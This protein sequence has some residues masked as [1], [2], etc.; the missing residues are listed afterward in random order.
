MKFK[1]HVFQVPLIDVRVNLRRCDVRVAEHFLDDAQ[2]RA[3]AQQMRGEAVAEQMRIHI[4]IEPGV[5]RD[6]LH[7][8][9]DA[10]R[11]EFSPAARGEENFA[12][13]FF[14]THSGRPRSM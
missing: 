9:P 13:R 11:R 2:V 4:E 8:L 12:A 5:L 3:V 7:D 6:L 1:M 14:V 10:H